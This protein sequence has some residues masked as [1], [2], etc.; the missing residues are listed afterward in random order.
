MPAVPRGDAPTSPAPVFAA[1]GMAHTVGRPAVLARLDA[2]G[3][4]PDTADEPVTPITSPPSAILAADG[5]P[6]TLRAWLPAANQT[7]KAV[8][9][10]VHGFNDYSGAFEPLGTALAEQGLA[11]YAYDQRG[12]GAT[13][14]RGVWPKQESLVTDLIAAAALIQARHPRLPFYLLGESMGAAVVMLALADQAAPL[15]RTVR[16]VVLVST[17]VWGGKALN[18]LARAMLL[19]LGTLLPRVRMTKPYSDARMPSD[20]RAML[21]AL[22]RD[23]LAITATR[24]SAVAGLVRLVDAAMAVAPRF[25][26]PGLVQFGDQD[27]VNPPA[28][29]RTFLTLLPPGRQRVL[30]YPEGW[31]MLLRDTKAQLVID[32]IV[33]WIGDPTTSALK[34]R[35]G[36]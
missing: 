20:N 16:G 29:V 24:I 15:R 6:L 19:G 23:P 33:A 21:D 3:T 12:F 22:W 25:D 10:A 36:S 28:A 26:L 18:P 30:F 34:G 32:D 4:M 17:A 11:A 7:A 8:V 9:L 35:A 13:R 1:S 27:R 14:D 31:H 2:T 5:E